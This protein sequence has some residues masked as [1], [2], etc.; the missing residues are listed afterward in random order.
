MKTLT[1]HRVADVDSLSDLGRSDVS[2]NGCIYIYT[3]IYMFLYIYI[4]FYVFEYFILSLCFITLIIY[5]CHVL[6]HTPSHIWP[7]FNKLLSI[8]NFLHEIYVLYKQL[9]AVVMREYGDVSVR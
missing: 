6:L 5:F 4:F 3:Y 9:V 1:D 8:V 2:V 7:E